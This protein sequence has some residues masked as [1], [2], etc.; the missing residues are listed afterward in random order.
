ML[1]SVKTLKTCLC[2][3]DAVHAISN[4]VTNAKM[5]MAEETM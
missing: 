3:W 2:Q 5:H 4:L 1:N